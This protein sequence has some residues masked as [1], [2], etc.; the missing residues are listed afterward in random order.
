MS[1]TFNPAHSAKCGLCAAF[2]AKAGFTASRQSL[3]S[4][5]GFL[6]LYAGDSDAHIASG[7]D[8]AFHIQR[9]T[10]KAFPCGAVAN[11]PIDACLRFRKEHG[12]S[13]DSIHEVVITVHPT[14]LQF[15]DR[16]SPSSSLEAKLSAYHVA[17]CALLHGWVKVGHFDLPML[18]DSSVLAVRN[19]IKLKAEASYH[20]DEAE[21][22]AVYRDGSHRTFRV[23]DAVGG[24]AN[25]LSDAQMREKFM[26]MG[27][28]VLPF[29]VLERVADEL[30]FLE[31]AKDVGAIAGRMAGKQHS[32]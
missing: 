7:S 15:M 13:E 31:H 20:R 19:K 27:D 12:F 5:R 32:S 3:E 23:S 24:L 21:V 22:T 10:Y 6:D 16:R 28:Q 11:A 29:A 9:N 17:A 26:D 1:K 25:P 30:S 4:K 14:V 18:K 2:F 8:E